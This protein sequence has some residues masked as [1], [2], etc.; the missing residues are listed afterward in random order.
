MN[1]FKVADKNF[2]NMYQFYAK[3]DDPE[4]SEKINYNINIVK[5]KEKELG[6][7]FQFDI[8]YIEE[9]IKMA[10]KVERDVM[11]AAQNETD[12]KCYYI[13][14]RRFKKST[15]VLIN[16][17]IY[18]EFVGDPDKMLDIL[19]EIIDEINLNTLNP[20]TSIIN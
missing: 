14:A 7:D 12:E 19:K 15:L 13:F 2:E 17:L 9:S 5:R 8:K 16:I 1:K 6:N 3:F 18:K 11:L 20:S 10:G 4:F